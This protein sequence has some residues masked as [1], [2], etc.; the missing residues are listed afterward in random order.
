VVASRAVIRRLGTGHSRPRSFLART[1]VGLLVVLAAIA[2]PEVA[3]AGPPG[4][5]PPR[6][7]VPAEA[8][9]DDDGDHG[10]S[11]KY[12]LDDIEVRGNGKTRSRV[13][14]RYVPFRPGDVIDVDDPQVELTRYRLLGTGFFREV[15]FSLRKGKGRGHVVLIIEVVERNTL[16]VNDLWMGLSA[17]SGTSSQKRTLAAYAGLDV[18][19]TNLAGTGIT[20]GTAV[21]LAQ[22]PLQVALR[23]RFFDPAFLGTKWM[24]S[25]TLLHNNATDFF[26][27]ERVFFDDRTPV[28]TS[29]RFA[30]VDYRRFGGSVGVGRDFSVSTQLWAHYRLERV[31]ADVP[32]AASHLRGRGDAATTEPIDF[33]IVRGPSVLTTIG[34]TLQHDTRDQ[35]FLTTHGWFA[36]VATEV[37][38]SPLGSDYP[39]SRVDVLASRWWALPAQHVLRL[40]VFGGAIAG[41]APFFERY[42]IGDLSEF[43]ASRVLGLNI[44]RRSAPNFFGTAVSEV[45]NGDY[46]G[47]IDVE[48]RI[49][50]YRGSRSVFGID[51]F[52]RA[53]VFAIAAQHDITHPPAGY[54]GAAL[55][56]VDFTANLG[57]QMDT[58]AGGF[59]FALANV[60]GFLPTLGNGK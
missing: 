49:P 2:R 42:Y 23:V 7:P 1:V 40:H 11:L 13:V 37:S 18:A 43:R 30:A 16:V 33:S 58:S 36:S 32:L 35:P 44:E 54:S 28:S 9:G 15:E 51:L 48:Y 55:I 14:L 6:S 24:T 50:L 59:T 25:G 47:K 8:P 52:A 21:G 10:A 19:E 26:G 53:G 17:E 45:R 39:Y 56:P 29:Q 57:V 34:A 22:D 4:P 3:V 20:L 12:T 46:A 27:N 41:R 60:I 31:D 5:L 38:L